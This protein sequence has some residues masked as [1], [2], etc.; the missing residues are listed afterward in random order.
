M[1]LI[2]QFFQALAKNA[3]EYYNTTHYVGAHCP[4]CGKVVGTRFNNDNREIYKEVRCPECGEY[5][6]IYNNRR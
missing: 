2:G 1:G 6:D 4:C 3:A 5:F